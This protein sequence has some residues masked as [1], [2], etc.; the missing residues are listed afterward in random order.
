MLACIYKRSESVYDTREL[1]KEACEFSR[2]EIFL[3]QLFYHLAVDCVFFRI[4]GV[5][6]DKLERI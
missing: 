6:E 2:S 1:I 3:E 4:D 5:K